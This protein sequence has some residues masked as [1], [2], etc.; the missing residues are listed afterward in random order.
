[1]DDIINLWEKHRNVKAISEELGLTARKTNK[2]ILDLK[3]KEGVILKGYQYRNR[4]SKENKPV[5]EISE[6]SVAPFALSQEDTYHPVSNVQLNLDIDNGT[7]VVFS[8]A[9]I[10]PHQEWSIAAQALLEVIAEINPT[11]IIDGGD[12]F[13]FA[14]ISKHDVLGWNPQ[15]TVAEELVAANEFL[16][17]VRDASK[18]SRYIMLESNH[19][20]RFNKFLA[21]HCPQFRGLKGFNFADQVPNWE[22][23]FSIMINDDIIFLHQYNNGV[24]AAYNNAMKGGISVITGHTHILEVKPFSDYRG[25]RFGV[26]TGTLATIKNN[27]LFNYTGNTPLNWQ[28]GFVV[29]TIKD[30]ELQYPEICSV[31]K[32][33]K[34]FFR[35]KVIG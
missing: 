5:E 8:D 32:Q 16:D 10:L 1:M 14:S 15:F 34:A 7:V 13:D 27:P 21:K 28:S 19:D 18:K 6:L 24:H 9:H 12:S 30:G 35:G 20:V 31:N 4:P 3:N 29:L 25:T 22:H 23:V 11:A 33:G 17:A 26:Q 2:I